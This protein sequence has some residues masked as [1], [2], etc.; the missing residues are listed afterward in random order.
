MERENK[1]RRLKSRV[2]ILFAMAFALVIG[3]SDCSKRDSDC[4][5][6]ITIINNTEKVLYF[7][8]SDK[9][10]DTSIIDYDPS[11]ALDFYKVKSYS[12]KIHYDRDGCFDMYLNNGNKLMYFLFDSLVLASVPW[13]S[14]RENYLIIKRYDLSLDDL[15]RMNWTITYP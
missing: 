3:G 11:L 4:H 14:V 10:P 5:N 6:E 8:Y 9:Y 2:P 1:N 15:N 13:D 12:S 7:Y